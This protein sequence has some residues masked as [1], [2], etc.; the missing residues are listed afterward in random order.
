MRITEN[1]M[2]ELMSGRTMKTQ[3]QVAEAGE[4]LSSGIAVDRPSDDPVRWADGMRTK[5]SMDRRD[6]HE[7]TV[8]RARDNL[9]RVDVAM[10]DLFEDLDRVRVLAMMGA[11]GTN[12]AANLMAAA[13]EVS[14]IFESMV[15][16]ANIRS[17][18]GEYLLAGSNST[19]AP[20]DANGV[21]QGNDVSR[22]IET[23]DGVFKAASVSG[24]LLTSAEGQDIFATVNNVRLALEANDSATVSGLLDDLAEALDQLSHARAQAGVAANSLDASVDVLSDLEVA[25]AESLE[26][27]VGQDP[28]EAATWLANLSNQL[29]ASRVVSERIVSL[30][31]VRG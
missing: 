2:L 16:S 3:S 14:A 13:V 26:T 27:S 12:D 24:A 18:D 7:S 30:M 9:L 23:A 21:F 11:N 6:S 20:F 15:A 5:L 8:E 19:V 22:Q 4:K 1:R 17:I 29:E 25:L 31:S 10:S 28:I